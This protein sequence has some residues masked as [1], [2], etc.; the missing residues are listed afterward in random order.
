MRINF[1]KKWGVTH[2]CFMQICL[3]Y[4]LIEDSSNPFSCCIF[5]VLICCFGWSFW[6]NSS[7]MHKQWEREE[8]RGARSLWFTFLR[9]AAL[10]Q[11]YFQSSIVNPVECTTWA[12]RKSS[13]LK[14][15]W[16]QIFWG[17]FNKVKVSSESLCL[18]QSTY[19]VCLLWKLRWK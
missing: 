7:L 18:W 6:R 1:S 15:V 5:F 9:T 4:D 3:L 17:T 14:C 11:Q 8:K 13:G 2:Y 16:L 10:K 12:L 19:F